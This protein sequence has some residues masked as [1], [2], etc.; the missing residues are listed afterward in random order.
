MFSCAV[1]L[2]DES[3]EESF[4]DMTVESIRM[5]VNGGDKVRSIH[6]AGCAHIRVTIITI[7]RNDT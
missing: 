6:F 7:R 4:S 1:C 5:I 2:A 3:R